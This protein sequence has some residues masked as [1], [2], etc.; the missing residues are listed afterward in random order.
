M[1]VEHSGLHTTVL[2]H[3]AIDA[4]VTTPSGTYVDA[5]FGRGG[6]SR[7]MLER[8]GPSARL[9]ALD[10]DPE[11]VAAALGGVTRIDDSRFSIHHANF[12]ELAQVLGSMGIAAVD[13]VL[14]DLGVSSP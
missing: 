5:T 7:L 14:L 11:A 6:H 2:L 13:G 1:T 12:S 4:L 3:E 8:L 9:L 10:R